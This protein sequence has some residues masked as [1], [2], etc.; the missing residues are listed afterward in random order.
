MKRI[1]STALCLALAISLYA[2]GSDALPF[3]CIDRN[4]VTSA[5][6][7]AGSASDEN[8]A[9]S[10]FGNASIIP[11]SEKVLDASAS[12]QYWAPSTAKSGHFNAGVSLKLGKR[13][14]ISAGY[15]MQRYG[16]MDVFDGDG[17]KLQPF[18][19]C[20]HLFAFG[21]GFGL[22]DHLSVGVNA[23]YAL[24]K[25]GPENRHGGF[26]G[27]LYL[28]WQVFEGLRLTAGVA[29]LG[30]R[31]KSADNVSYAQPAH[32][33]AGV[34]WVMDFS[35]YH[36]VEL[37]GD[38]EYYFSRNYAIAAGVQYAYNGVV[39]VRGGYR[40]AS[41]GCVIPSHLGIG[42]GARFAGFR[43]DVGYITASAALKNTVTAGLGFSF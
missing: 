9:Y 3:T 32:C 16:S 33:K 35:Y 43:I 12:Y 21:T 13:F 8:I 34:D 42:I 26:S 23:R 25:V 11:L 37:V 30:N 41:P 20:D 27:D 14:G 28:A 22:T 19:P 4:P 15:A 31:V 40:F 7:G 36:T 38:A 29:T 18:S 39:Y 24:E 10:A 2:Q 5:F 17:N 6:A 1:L